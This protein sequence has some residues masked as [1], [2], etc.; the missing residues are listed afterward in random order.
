VNERRTSFLCPRCGR[1]LSAGEPACPYCGLRSPGAAWRRL[2]P[3]RAL[4]DPD[5]LLRLI[6]G[7]NIV[8]FAVALLLDPAAAGFT[9]NPLGLFRPSDRALFALGAT[10][11]IPIDGYGRLWTL[12]AA[13]YLHA[14]LLHIAFN[15]AALRQLGLIVG[16]EYGAGRMFVIYTVAGVC[17]FVASWAVGVRL[18]VGASAGVCGLVG[19]ILYYGKSRGG[20][21]G[22]ALYR[23]VGTWALVLFLFGFLVP[24][25]NNWAHGGGLLAGAL[26][27]RLLGYTERRREGA[28]HRAL[29][30]ALLALTALVLLIA[31]G[32]GL[33]AR[34][35]R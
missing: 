2:L 14:G 32:H 27:G 5:L 35:G 9:M 22:A 29:A 24:G 10:G 8:L 17:G 25:I 34:F 26:A 7:A 12:L 23:Q 33:A 30:A 31:L 6:L 1:L 18:T 28:A 4:G 13:G 21:Y 16:R 11:T 3:V 20:S 19:A 15:L